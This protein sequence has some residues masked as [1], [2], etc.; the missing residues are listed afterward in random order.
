MTR[1]A[2]PNFGNYTIA[3]AASVESLGVEPW[4]S[5]STPETTRLGMEAAP[6]STCLPFKANLG[7]FLKAAREG[8]EYAVM[9]NS[10]GT[11]RLR[12]YR[13]L[14]QKILDNLGIKMHIFSL[15][16]DGFKPPLIRHFNPSR[17]TFLAGVA[18][19]A[20][21]MRVVD[22]LELQAWRTRALELN[23]G[24]TSRLMHDC[25]RELEEAKT[26]AT[27]LR[28][29]R[30]IPGRFGGIPVEEG[31]QP[32]KVALVGEATVLRDKFLN[33]NVEDI[34][35]A[36]GVEVFNFFLLGVE[37]RKIFRVEFGSRTSQR[38]RLKIA[39][40][41]LKTLVGGHAIET[42]S[43]TIRCAEEGYD[44]AVH[45]YPTGCMPEVSIKPIL[46]KISKDLGIPVLDCS[47]DEHTTQ[48]GIVTR[49]ETF[50]DLLHERKKM[51]RERTA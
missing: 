11:C 21:K 42:V 14:Q 18:R 4:S 12:Y 46:K 34:L 8:V 23:P 38:A 36:L 51:A 47:F 10:V 40:P 9:A 33:H 26:V 19:A 7:H 32:L 1:V 24:G 41:Y 3:L 20:L 13:D 16:Y 5:T 27:I 49:I 48:V 17:S 28:L 39:R 43:N 37:L 35:G 45:I 25:L 2:V 6:E 22:R 15:G 31:R 44:G 29:H 50:V 30:A